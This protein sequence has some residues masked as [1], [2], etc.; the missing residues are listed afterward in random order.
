MRIG[1][2]LPP[3]AAPISLRDIWVGIKGLLRGQSEIKR[4]ESE[5]RDYFKVDYCFLVSS[6]TASLTLILRA[7]HDLFPERDE[8]IIPAFTCYSVPSAIVRAGLRISLCDVDPDTLDFDFERLSTLLSSTRLL[9]IIPTHLFALPADIERVRQLIKSPEVTIIEDAAQ[10]MGGKRND[11]LMGT[12]GDV[13]FFS[14]GRGKALSTV[15]GGIVL[16][17]RDDIAA[18]IRHHVGSLS[19][20][21]LHEVI[22][23]ILKAVLLSVFVR[24]SL[25]W[26][27]K[28]LPFLKLGETLFNPTFKMKGM[29][30]FQAGLARE[31]KS[32]LDALRTIRRWQIKSWVSMMKRMGLISYVRE[33]A[34]S[35]DLI[36]FPI[37]LRDRS[38][39]Q[40]LYSEG[41]LESLGIMPV[42][43]DSIDGIP[44]LGHRIRSFPQ[45][46]NLAET[47]ITL[48][49]HGFVTERDRQSIA[50]LIAHI[51]EK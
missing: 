41:K 44:E 14:L 7:L 40:K 3:A 10:A 6:G 46:R 32:K 24:P 51:E 13:S 33:N 9:A 36:R 18:K 19:A 34:S 48:P 29:S 38:Q 37:K 1:R 2:T 50:A 30:S 20:Y 26:F 35:P 8:V 31:W 12:L 11:R 47:L 49:V 28:S 15:E 16:S 4:F 5:L 45:A 21:R 17:N 22:H 23:L 39:V 27:P 25:F 43:P 42:Y